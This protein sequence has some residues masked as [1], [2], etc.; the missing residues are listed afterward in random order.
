MR[1]SI[2]I[3]LSKN[4]I[5]QDYRR[6]ILSLMKSA[7]SA[8][9]G[10]TLISRYYKSA[11]SKPMTWGL[12]LPHP[13]YKGREITLSSLFL[14]LVISTDDFQ[15]FGD[16]YNGFNALR[17]KET[18]I[19]GIKFKVVSCNIPQEIPV[20]ADSVALKLLSPLV[21]RFHTSDSQCDT[22][23]TYEHEEFAEQLRAVT[24]IQLKTAGKDT[25]LADTLNVEQSNA[26][27]RTVI[28]HYGKYIPVT[29][30]KMR[31]CG[32]PELLELLR[33]IGIGSHRNSGCGM[34]DVLSGTIGGN[35]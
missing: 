1:L 35:V 26:L 19:S 7:L 6:L 10:E 28:L 22:Y 30:G 3:G 16:Y 34:F 18:E 32:D 23:Y 17:N 15:L 5:S 13:I 4:V 2:G 27:R 33:Q 20:E 14:K 9:G 24:R 29:I 12:Y 31:L 8:Y 21:V 25:S 11:L